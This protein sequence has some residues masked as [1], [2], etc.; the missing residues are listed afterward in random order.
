MKSPIRFTG[1][2]FVGSRGKTGFLG[3]AKVFA[4]SFGVVL[5]PH[6]VSVWTGVTR[7]W[8]VAF[9]VG[10]PLERPNVRSCRATGVWRVAAGPFSL[11]RDRIYGETT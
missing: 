5:L 7:H 6:Q 11:R 4:A 9:T 8:S 3:E 10:F 1:E 2:K